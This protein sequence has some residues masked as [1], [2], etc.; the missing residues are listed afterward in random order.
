MLRRR[1]EPAVAAYS[2]F[3]RA[4]WKGLDLQRVHAP[5]G[6]SVAPAGSNRSGGGGNETAGAFDAKG[7]L[8]DP[9]SRQAVTRVNA[10]QA[11]KRAMWEP[12]RRRNG[13]GRSHW[14][15]G[16]HTPRSDANQWSHRGSGDGM[17][18]REIRRNTGNPG[19]RG[20]WPQPGAREGQTGP[21]RVADRP[22]VLRRPGNAGGGKGPE[23]KTDVR[24]GG[25][26][27]RLAMSLP[28]PPK[29]QKL[30]EALHAKAK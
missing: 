5:P 22:V 29:V 27:G 16:G 13:E 26:A 10:E 12:T 18:A 6:N 28:P 17:P 2:I 23:F 21:P 19:G 9:A 14:G 24:S 8:G 3:S 4:P 30:Q 11:S 20:A 15:I 1:T 7:R 25:R